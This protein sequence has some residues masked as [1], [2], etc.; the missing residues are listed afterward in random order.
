MVSILKKFLALLLVLCMTAGLMAGCGSTTESTAAEA[1][2]AAVESEAAAETLAEEEAPAEE[3][4]SAEEETAVVEEEA[5]PAEA[6]PTAHAIEVFGIEEAPEAISYPL[7]T[8]ETLEL[9]ATF[10]DPLFASYPNAMADCQIYIE[11]EKATGVKMTYNGLSTSA[12]SEQF[13]IIM[14]SGDYPDLIGWGLNY[15]TGDDSAI[16]DEVYLDLTE[17]IAEYAPNYWGVLSS[18]DELLDTAITDGGYIVGFHAVRTEESLGKAGLVIRTDLLEK[19]G[20]EKPYTI[21]EFDEVLAMFQSEGLEQPLMMLAPGAIQDN[22]LAAAYDVAA[23]CNSFPQPVAPTYVNN[24]EIKFGPL[25]DGFKEYILKVKEWYDKGYIH[26]DFITLNSNWN[27][28]DYSNAIT[29]GNAGIFYADWGNLGGYVE[30]SEVEGFAIEATYDMHATEDSVNHFAQYTKKSVG[31][32]FKITTDCANIELA[33]QWGD[34]WYSEEGSLLANYGVEGVSFE[35]VDGTPMF[36]ETVTDAPEGMRDALLIYASNDTIC[37]VIDGNAVAS[38]YSELDKAAPE[39]WATGMDDSFVIPSTVSLSAEETTEATGIYSDIQTLCLESIAKF[40]SGDK[41]MDEY[42][43][44][45]ENLYALGVE[46]YL[47]IY[48]GAYDRAMGA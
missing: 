7:D 46:D 32:G 20:M 9:M 10:P 41:S 5:A 22:W 4:A 39:I 21:E 33:C 34:W 44:F 8:D 42:D 48:Q 3:E 47:A 6:G 18:D 31:N 1:S 25:E 28:P 13:N 16:E 14:A 29:G 43:A 19:N 35:Y 11:A 17:Y 24:G 26:S 38:G 12:S 30:A 37:C 15:A 2:S 36:T 45:V 23:F 40:I 27:G